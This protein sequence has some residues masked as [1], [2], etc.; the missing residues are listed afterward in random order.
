[1]VK[2]TFA[3]ADELMLSNAR[4]KAQEEQPEESQ[5]EEVTQEVQEQELEEEQQVEEEANVA[6]GDSD[7]DKGGVDDNATPEG[8]VDKVDGPIDDWLA[9]DELGEQEATAAPEFN[10]DEL[11][12]EVGVEFKSRDELVNSI[13]QLKEKAE[14]AESANPYDGIPDDLAEVVD[15]A[16]TGEDYRA[17]MSLA[18]TD[19]DSISDAE[20]V[21][22][23][24]IQAFKKPDGSIDHDRLDAYMDGLS[25]DQIAIQGVQIRN[26]LKNDQKLRL[27]QIKSQAQAKAAKRE[28]DIKSAVDNLSEVSGFK[29]HPKQKDM[30]YRNLMNV[31]V[32]S[33]SKGANGQVDYAKVARLMFIDKYF[34]KML[35]Y[36]KQRAAT[37][38]KR[39]MLEEV[40]NVD[41]RGRGENPKPNDPTPP[42][43]GLDLFKE[44]AIQDSTYRFS[45]TD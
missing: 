22:Q 26:T 34:D 6:N 7:A 25:D 1:M 14:K 17:Y 36:H 5:Q 20:L 37:D 10:F 29:V 8:E 15:I 44:K 12:K 35:G 33:L 43:S 39:K 30:L 31:G 3:N 41:T 9:E 27:S 28:A 4:G 23:S 19:Y 40:S 24:V 42:K 32:D 21:E 2:K 16:K 45:R 18:N 13:K 38:Q 11:S